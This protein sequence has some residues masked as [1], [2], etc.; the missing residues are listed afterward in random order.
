[1]QHIT[2]VQYYYELDHRSAIILIS[3]RTEY[4]VKHLVYPIYSGYST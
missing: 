2:K 1:M 4:T 3:I